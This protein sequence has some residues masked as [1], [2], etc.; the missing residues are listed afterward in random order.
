MP[1]DSQRL[2]DSIELPA[3]VAATA[4]GG[5]LG[6]RQSG[7]VVG[8]AQRAARDLLRPAAVA[9]MP[10]LG[11][12]RAFLAQVYAFL[13]PWAKAQPL[14]RFCTRSLSR[15]IFTANLAGLI[16]LLSGFGVLTYQHTWLIDAKAESLRTQARMIAAAVASNAKI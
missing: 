6:W 13:L 15:R 1:L 2:P 11:R 16:I 14:W 4:A 3:D 9:L 5:A 8:K 10:V 12:A 7:L